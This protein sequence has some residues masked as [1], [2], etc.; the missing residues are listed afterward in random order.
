MLPAMDIWGVYLISNVRDKELHFLVDSFSLY[1]L[2]KVMSDLPWFI[3]CI[4][5]IPNFPRVLELFE[6]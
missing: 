4:V 2:V 6:A 1:I 3:L 5:N